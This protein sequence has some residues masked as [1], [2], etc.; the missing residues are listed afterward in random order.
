MQRAS[1]SS[2]GSSRTSSP[3]TPR[4]ASSPRPRTLCSTAT[5]APSSSPL[6]ARA[7]SAFSCA[8]PTCSRHAAGAAPSSRVRRGCRSPS[9]SSAARACLAHRC[10]ALRTL[11][12]SL[13]CRDSCRRRWRAADC[14]R[15]RVPKPKPPQSRPPNPNPL[16]SPAAPDTT[17][18]TP[19]HPV[20][21][22]TLPAE[23]ATQTPQMSQGGF[24][25]SPTCACCGRGV[26]V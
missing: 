5:C 2:K 26:K 17:P 23:A 21:Q 10:T 22:S 18:R 14:P 20:G 12:R 19:R 6:R 15:T 9:P 24:K 16:N 13:R 25:D 8:R 4:A 7:A 11:A 3:L 1:T